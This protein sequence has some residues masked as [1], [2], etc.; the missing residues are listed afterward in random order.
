MK[1]DP[2]ITKRNQEIARARSNGEA[3][4]EE[5]AVK[6]GISRERVRQ[7]CEKQ[8]VDNEIATK[9]YTKNKSDRRFDD[10]EESAGVILMRFIAGDSIPDIAKTVRVSA[11][12]TQEVLDEQV[13]PEVSAARSRNLIAKR[14][15][16]PDRNPSEVKEIRSDRHWTSDRVIESLTQFA[17][18]QGGSLPTS[19]K[20]PE[21]VKNSNG[22][23]P[24]FPTVRNRV[25][26]WSE[27]RVLINNKIKSGIA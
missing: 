11:K 4:L 16:S 8:G 19:N 14:G 1:T 20:Y 13:T 22:S 7:I 12:L 3:S 21:F 26:R 6:Y 15:L 24:S 2:E 9:L 10:A 5:L 27:V 25:G 18:S 23:L 17:L